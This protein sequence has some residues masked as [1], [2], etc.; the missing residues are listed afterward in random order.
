MAFEMDVMDVI[1][2]F[3]YGLIYEDIYMTIPDGMITPEGLINPCVKVVRAL[4]GLKQSGRAWYHRYAESLLADGYQTTVVNP[5]IF[6]KSSE[7]GRVITSIYRIRDERFG[8][9]EVL[10]WH[11]N[12]TIH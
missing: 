12:R 10:H 2:A 9:I 6:Y 8:T 1:T 11:P 5:C 7:L 3:L 4:Y